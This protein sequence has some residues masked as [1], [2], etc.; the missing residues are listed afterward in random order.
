MQH[1]RGVMH[2]N[3][4]KCVP[5]TL[6]SCFCRDDCLKQSCHSSVQPADV[7][8]PLNIG[9]KRNDKG[10]KTHHFSSCLSQVKPILYYSLHVL[11]NIALKHSTRTKNSSALETV[12]MPTNSETAS[13]FTF[14]TTTLLQPIRISP[15][16]T[17]SVVSTLPSQIFIHPCALIKGFLIIS[18]AAYNFPLP[19]FALVQDQRRKRQKLWHPPPSVFQDS[20]ASNTHQHVE[21]RPF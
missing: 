10:M 5:W 9:L 12:F 1:Y 11:P 2:R 13:I 14:P 21:L 19:T 8:P 18:T 16:W 4:G 7:S 6:C 15:W 20:E 3:T 17:S